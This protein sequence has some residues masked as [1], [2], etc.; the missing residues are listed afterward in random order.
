METKRD[1]NRSQEPV[2]AALFAVADRRLELEEETCLA[3]NSED[4]NPDAAA[5]MLSN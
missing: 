1:T 5:R 3:A 4:V 2:E